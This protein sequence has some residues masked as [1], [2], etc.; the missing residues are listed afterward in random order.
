MDNA[1]YINGVFE[2]VL[3]EIIRSQ[4]NNPSKIF[5]LQ[6]YSESS[7]KQLKEAPPTIESPLPLY[8]STTA[9][10]NQICYSAEIVG[11]E[12]KN[13]IPPERKA[14]LNEHIKQFQPKEGEIYPEARG[15]KCV[16]LISIK[17]LQKVS[18]QFSTSNLI[19]ESNG[20][21]L[22]PRSQSGGWSYVYA[23]PLLSIEKTFVKSRLD[24][25][26]ENAVSASSSDSGE[27]LRK[28]LA[29][30]PKIPDKVQTISYDFRRN[31]DVIVI[32]LKRAHGKCEL[33]GS[34]APFCK[35]SNGSPYLE[36]HHWITLSEGG[37]DTI[38]NAGAL[39]PNC[40]KQ[41]HFGQYREYIKSNKALPVDAKKPRG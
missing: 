6:P 32:V 9:Q 24:G 11:W 7:I 2:D 39:C 15:K 20:E 37:E 40:H 30:A 21:P 13:E 1:L 12:D 34:D 17:N 35:A 23:L 28:R 4:E 8:I 16:N 27:L 38:E 26:L 36:V 10:L 18:N 29:E 14:L 25:E 41:A 3:D 19:K 31:P 5:Y 22:K 33:C